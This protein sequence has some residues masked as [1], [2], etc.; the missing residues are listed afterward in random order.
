MADVAGLRFIF[1]IQDKVSAKL[2]KIE[3][4]SQQAAAKIAK[5]F[6]GASR[7]VQTSSQAQARVV[8][9]STKTQIQVEKAHVAAIKL[10]GREAA[11]VERAHAQAIRM[12]AKENSLATKAFRASALL[13]TGALV[14]VVAAFKKLG[15]GLV[16][17][18]T[19][20]NQVKAVTG[21]TGDQM[22]QFKQQALD[23]G[24]TT[25]FTATEAAQAQDYLARAG[26]NVDQ[27]LAAMPGTLQLAAAGTLDLGRAADIATDIM[28]GYRLSVSELPRV[29]DT[30]A[31]TAAATNTSIE[32]LGNAMAYAGPVASAA[33]LKF[34]ETSAALGLLASAGY[35]GERGGTAL[36]GAMSK[37][38]A[39]STEAAGIL[40]RLGVSATTSTGQLRPLDEIIGQLETSGITSGEAIQIFGQKAGPGMLALIGQG[41]EALTTL[42][43]DLEA[44]GG[45]AERM[46]EDQL[47]GFV[48]VVTSMQSAMNN[49]ALV[50]ADRLEPAMTVV[51][52]TITDAGR[53]V[54]R[55]LQGDAGLTTLEQT[56]RAVTAGVAASA[57]AFGIYR[58]SVLA[59][60][61][62]QKIATVAAKLFNVTMKILNGTM[63]L[64]PLGLVLTAIGLVVAAWVTWGDEIKGFLRLVWAAMLDKIGVGLQKL[65][66]F[67]GIFKSDWA[68]AM[69]A[70]GA[71]LQD[72]KVKM[73]ATAH[74]AEMMQAVMEHLG[75]ITTLD[76]LSSAATQLA[77]QGRGSSE[78]MRQI[79]ARAMTL[80]GEGDKLDAVLTN[81]VKAYGD[82]PPV[83]ADTGE[84]ARLAAEELDKLR[85]AEDALLVVAPKVTRSFHDLLAAAGRVPD[86]NITPWSVEATTAQIALSDAVIGTAREL[87]TLPPHFDAIRRELL[88]LPTDQAIQ[89]FAQLNAVWESMD[90]AK[91][92]KATDAYAKALQRAAEQGIALNDA[93]VALAEG[94]GS[95]WLDRYREIL[96]PDAIGQTLARAF[97]GAAG[98]MGALKS[99]AARVDLSPRVSRE[100]S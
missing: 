20:L 95:K 48:G 41:S 50:V 73:E 55:L 51:A 98:F 78:V 15:G 49:V 47:T 42:T 65:S 22:A 36:R 86:L 52:T 99:L 10:R 24:A 39:P 93:Q 8:S 70:A 74:E 58:V 37:L 53:S 81:I 83:I 18:Q 75:T 62:A 60:A 97:E 64:N 26:L 91:K 100:H 21:A 30:L 68:E 96:S 80:Q 1:D 46:A 34:E 90:E 35:K 92:A 88:G 2:G 13:T 28:S 61:G 9:Q 66:T 16:E 43:S 69:D 76:D 17:F 56:V 45:A 82:L 54:V 19:A 57:S 11:Q 72:V 94:A 79:A 87:E 31:A 3:A 23:L 29:N 25:K 63:R 77:D 33:G 32:Q 71:G 89:E 14:G 4:R 12:R 38:L 27:V 59:Y 85:R 40:A 67:V 84:A 7:A 44:S 6:T 5:G